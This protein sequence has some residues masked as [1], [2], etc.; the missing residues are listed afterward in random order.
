ME[1]LDIYMLADAR[2][3]QIV[4]ENLEAIS[5]L[6][7]LIKDVPVTINL[8]MY[9]VYG[10]PYTEDALN[11]HIWSF[12]VAHDYNTTTTPQLRANAISVAGNVL[13]IEISNMNTVELNEQLKEEKSIRLGAELYGKSIED[14][15][16]N[17]VMQFNVSIRNRRESNGVPSEVESNYYTKGEVDAKFIDKNDAVSKF[18]NVNN[19]NIPIVDGTVSGLITGELK[20]TRTFITIPTSST[21][22]TIPVSTTDKRQILLQVNTA[23]GTTESGI[24]LY[25]FNPDATYYQPFFLR[26]KN[27]TV[28]NDTTFSGALKKGG[29]DVATINDIDEKIAGITLDVPVKVSEL[30]N[31]AGYI[32]I[33]QIPE[34]DLSEY[35]L[36]TDIPD[37]SS[38]ITADALTG[39]ALKSEIPD[40]TEKLDRSGKN[41]MIVDDGV[42]TINATTSFDINA[43]FSSFAG[44]KVVCYDGLGVMND[45]TLNSNSS[46]TAGG[47]VVVGSNGK[48]P[49]NL[50][51]KTEVDLTPYALKTE[52]PVVDVNKAYVDAEL[53]KKLNSADAFSGSYN[54]LTDVPEIPVVPDNITTQGNVFNGTNQLV[55]TDDTG[56][57]PAELYDAGSGAEYTAE[58]GIT[59]NDDIISLD[60]NNF[61]ITNANVIIGQN[62]SSI[63]LKCNVA[64]AGQTWIIPKVVQ[65]AEV[66]SYY[67]AQYGTYNENYNAMSDYGNVHVFSLSTGT[68]CTLT[69]SSIS[70]YNTLI[71]VVNNA[72]GGSL[73][74]GNEEV[75][76]GSENGRYALVFSNFLDSDGNNNIK[77][78]NKIEV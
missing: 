40:V 55:K 78:Y 15:K 47:L 31:D 58:N 10:E 56:K 24:S 25:F 54:D 4:D 44:G 76:T 35:A 16:D 46:N 38:F 12:I 42:F 71:C 63:K 49:E 50:Y 19:E 52:L 2:N 23:V 72:N 73:L 77:L 17:W 22:Q 29:Y 37:V 7:T 61:K 48:I 60:S 53:A 18:I 27:M 3:V 70:N 30:E 62:S 57:I 13:K 1:Y 36:K 34:V 11:N 74:F 21:V 45:I 6:V 41:Q 9:D 64:N 33:E 67:N 51:D 26:G 39:Y 28:N 59:I 75:I 65:Y 68:P 20:G 32:T 5:G 14:A 43:P 66:G 69:V 8:H